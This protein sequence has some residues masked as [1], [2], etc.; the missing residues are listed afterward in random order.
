MRQVLAI[1]ILNYVYSC[2][3]ESHTD[4]KYVLEKGKLTL[5]VT[6]QWLQRWSLW[7][8]SCLQDRK[9]DMVSWLLK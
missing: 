1:E 5:P 2:K 9:I 8:H 4:H 7:L 3:V 6:S